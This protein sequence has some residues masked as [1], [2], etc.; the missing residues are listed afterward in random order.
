ML[1][2][3]RQFAHTTIKKRGLGVL[4]RKNFEINNCALELNVA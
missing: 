1:A 4:D 3:Y 2:G